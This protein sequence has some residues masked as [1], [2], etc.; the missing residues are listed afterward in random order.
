MATPNAQRARI[1]D[2]LVGVVCERGYA[3]VS[4][5]LVCTR[6]RVSHHTFYAVFDSLDDS[7]LALLDENAARVDGLISGAF[8]GRSNW[9]DGV[10]EALAELLA[11]FDGD[12]QLAHVLLVEA[13]AAGSWS[14]TRREEQVAML[15]QT[16]VAR[17]A[18]AAEEWPHP[19]AAEGV[20]ASL[21]GVLHTHVVTAPHEPFSPLLGSLM[22]IA[23]APFLPAELVT[24]EVKQGERVAYANMA[25]RGL[26]GARRARH[27]ALEETRGG[28]P[29][30][31]RDPRAHR[32]RACL[33]YL[34]EHP[35]ASNRQIALAVG[36]GGHAQTSALLARLARMGLLDKQAGRPGY[37]NAWTLS[38]HGEQAASWL[39][40]DE[41]A[42]QR[43][44]E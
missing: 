36:I 25:A 30:A 6:A 28:L 16:I 23:T 14:R 26:G 11:F 31:L 24:R 35:G 2:A 3:D 10:R 18:P 27:D 43:S 21:L 40:L 39:A 32:V 1:F 12:P 17:W 34:A 7:F 37:P 8:E 20:M 13:T 4:V 19:R 38:G 42:S 9:V 33:G 44:Y 22:G 5:A 41:S 29:R 15:R